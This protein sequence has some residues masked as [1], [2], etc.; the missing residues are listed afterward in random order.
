LPALEVARAT[1]LPTVVET[2]RALGEIGKPLHFH[3]HDGHPIWALSPYGVA[4]HISFLERISIPFEFEGRRCLPL[5]FGPAGLAAIVEAA[6][7]ALQP[8]Q[9]SL[10]LEIHPIPGRLRLGV[11]AELFRHW[12][13]KKNAERTNY[14]LEVILANAALLRREVPQMVAR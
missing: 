14:W 8:D 12:R 7:G 2:V 11:H 1:C 9:L 4:D 10:T 5:L 6:L 13:D 3:L